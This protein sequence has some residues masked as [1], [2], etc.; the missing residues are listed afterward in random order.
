VAHAWGIDIPDHIEDELAKGAAGSPHHKTSM[1]QD[2]EAGRPLELDPIV[3]AVIELAR[4][5][6]VP[7]PTI[8][9]LWALTR[10]KLA[11]TRR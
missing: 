2:Y 6:D 8:E 5:R 9:T 3:N 4:R 1:L 7:V 10:V 11:A